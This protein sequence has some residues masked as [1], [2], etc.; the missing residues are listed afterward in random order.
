MLYLMMAGV[1]L[2]LFIACSNVANLLLARRRAA[3]R[4]FAVRTAIGAGR[5]RIVRQLLIESVVLGM[6]SVPLGVL[7][8]EA[9]T[10]LIAAQMLVDQV[11]YYIRWDVDSRSLLRDWRRRRDRADLR[12]V[13]AIQTTRRDVHESLKEGTRG[14]SIGAS[15]LAAASS[16]CRC[17]SRWSRSGALLFVR[18][19]LNLD[20]YNVGFD[21]RPL[22]TMRFY[23]TGERYEPEGAKARRVEDIVRRV[24][25]LTGVQAA[26]A[27]NL[28]PISGGGGGGEV[29]VDGK[30]SSAARHP[31]FHSS[32]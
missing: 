12:L 19:F 29:E 31:G 10:R 11:P 2:V 14:N 24:E 27:S 7:L 8:A 30:P 5:T 17:R 26:F 15:L 25:G 4:E 16:S 28:I 6:A 21:T 18:T 13:P 23:M 1:T 32:E 3:R 9:G 22:M 20:S